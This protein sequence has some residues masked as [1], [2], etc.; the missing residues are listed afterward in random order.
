MIIF[1]RVNKNYLI[2]LLLCVV[3]AFQGCKKRSE[4]ADMFYKK[5]HNKVFKDITPEGFAEV[6]KKTLA[7]KKTAITRAGFI[8]S[9]YSKNNYK[10]QFITNHLFNNNLLKACAYYQKAGDHGLNPQMFEAAQIKQL[11]NKLYTKNCIK[12]A[13]EA[14]RDMA[15]L[16]IAAA[17]SLINYTNALQYGVVN[18]PKIYRR[19]FM[20]TGQPDSLSMLRVFNIGN[21]AR[22][23]DSIQP[24][25]A[26]YLALQKALAGVVHAP[27]SQAEETRRILMVN[28]E[29]LRWKNK[30]SATK[31]VM[32]NIPDYY[33]TVTDSGHTVLKMKVCVG[34]GRNMTGAN[35]LLAYNDTAKE[36]K[37]FAHE[38]PELN[39]LI[40]SVEVNP[41]WNI[42][43]SI[44]NKEII[45]EAA[46]DRFYL[47]NK[48]IDVYKND[49]PVNDPENIDWGQVTK[50]NSD[51]EFK[52]KPGA[53]NSLGKIKFMFK[54]KSSVY[55]HDTPVKWAFG[56]KM[57]AISHG[58][59]RLNDAQ[60]LALSLFGD[61][62]KY[63]T[64]VTDMG[65]ANPS[66]TTIGL[67]KKVPV[68][69]TYVTCWADENGTLQFR[70][71]VYGLDIVL[72]DH[73][74]RYHSIPKVN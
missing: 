57:R 18:P 68:Y 58:C 7:A 62:Q 13:N 67:S 27:G 28:L 55:L 54:N 34:E 63:Q 44:A 74:Q 3:L 36:D 51:Y 22:Y 6:F 10:P 70:H 5:T 61:G 46:K 17:N 32:V 50:E 30:P 41:V 8:S 72:Y 37:P 73:L 9:Y 52:Q 40:H 43:N 48:S 31:Y 56:K 25:D 35:T 1:S 53:D 20:A 29:R 24:K 69:I 14:Y 16:E 11:I 23:L 64:I 65:A 42:P 60:A 45:I 38:T 59:I 39:S 21:M 2:V 19:Y 4:L 49:K 26:Q 47:A 71:D 33:L 12:T 15:E 66:P